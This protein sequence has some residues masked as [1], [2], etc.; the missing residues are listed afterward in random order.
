MPSRACPTPIG[1]LGLVG[2]DEGLGGVRW[3]CRGLDLD[4]GCA[5][6]DEA[7]AQIEAYFGGRLTRFD[8][9]LDVR[10]TDFQLACW[11]ALAEIPYGST[12]SYGAQARRL[13]FG[14]DAARAVGAANAQNPVPIVLPCHRVVRADG[15]LTG[16]GGGLPLKQALLEHEARGLAGGAPIEPTSWPQAQLRLL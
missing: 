2:S 1:L 7:A 9:P 10:G 6:L 11:Y 12:V 5:L 16:F 15:S 13:G 14:P 4:E 3:S 8:L